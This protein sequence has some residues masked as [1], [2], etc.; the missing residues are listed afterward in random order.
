MNLGTVALIPE[1]GKKFGLQN[2]FENPG[3]MGTVPTYRV[4]G[5]AYYPSSG[6][7]PTRSY[8]P[9]AAGQLLTATAIEN[10]RA[11]VGEYPRAG[12]KARIL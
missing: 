4:P 7:C 8:F 2:I 11:R 3:I 9:T 12:C 5:F 6:D 1:L 10:S